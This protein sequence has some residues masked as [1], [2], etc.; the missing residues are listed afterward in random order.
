MHARR[1]ESPGSLAATGRD[2]V[3]FSEHCVLST[4]GEGANSVSAHLI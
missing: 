4:N 2:L 3:G 1:L